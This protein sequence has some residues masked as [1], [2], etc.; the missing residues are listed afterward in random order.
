MLAPKSICHENKPTL[1]WV[2][3]DLT[4]DEKSKKDKRR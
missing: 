3:L 1:L 2:N 4:R